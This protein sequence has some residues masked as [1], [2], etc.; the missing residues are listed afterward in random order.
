MQTQN[1]EDILSISVSQKYY[2]TKSIIAGCFLTGLFGSS[3]MVYKNFKTAG[4]NNKA[5]LTIAIAIFFT[6]LFISSIFIETLDKIPGIVYSLFNTLV[7]AILVNIFQR[8]LIK[9]KLS[10]G[11]DYYPTSNVVIVCIIGLVLF[12]AIS[13]GV[14]LSCNLISYGETGL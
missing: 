2:S 6:G 9:E 14:I 13:F 4:L 3:Y 5:N 10:T 12:L 8:D 1:T 7:T 11:A